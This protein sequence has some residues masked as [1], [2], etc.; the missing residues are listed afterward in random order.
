MT[1][2]SKTGS[3]HATVSTV[4]EHA[5]E[6]LYLVRPSAE[7]INIF[8]K[9]ATN[10]D[11]PPLHI[12]ATKAELK[13][14]R[15]DF[16]RASHA[17]DLVKHDQLTLTATVPDGWGTV[18]ATDD[19][20]HA[21][22]HIQNH[23]L[24]FETTDV[25]E[26]L[27]ETCANYHAA[28]ERFTLR[29]PAWSTV[30]ETLT[31]ALGAKVCEDFTTAIEELATL[32]KPTLDEVDAALV[33]AARHEALL[34]DLTHWA[35]DIQFCSKATFSRTKRDFEDLDILESEKV[36]I[37]VGRPRLRVT[38]T[39]EYASLPVPELLQEINAVKGD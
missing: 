2:Q 1:L 38:L 36:P 14:I 33:V 30:T 12:F 15:N 39:D 35:E 27:L 5:T 21:F 29:T 11:T 6:P 7:L 17:A 8:V 22:A 24:S 3:V 13:S 4:L 37:D 20:A 18:A 26:G 28:S 9:T 19:T 32:E 16:H 10:R 25:P 34:Y 23:E 31:E